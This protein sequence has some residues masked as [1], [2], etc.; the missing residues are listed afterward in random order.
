SV[1]LFNA[2]AIQKLTKEDAAEMNKLTERLHSLNGKR[3]ALVHGDWILEVITFVKFGHVCLRT[4]FIRA[5]AAPNPEVA[6][7][8]GDIANQK[9]RAKHCFS[10]KRIGQ[11]TTETESFA[12]AMSLFIKRMK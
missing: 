3:N 7:K 2:R 9:E 1:D 12:V 10:V 6:G 11:V 8:I 5:S 4:R